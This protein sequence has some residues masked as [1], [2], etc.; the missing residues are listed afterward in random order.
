MPR[1]RSVAWSEL[2][3]GI[4]AVV[5]LAVLV[6]VIF[7]VGGEGGFWWDRYP[8]KVRFAD[9]QGLKAGAV[10]RVSGKEVGT[11]KAVEFA[12]TE[13][14]VD[15]EVLKTVRPLI[16]TESVASIGSLS[17]LGEPLVDVSAATGGTPLADNAVVKAAPK[18]GS[19]GDLTNSASSS[20]E[21]INQ[22]VADV[23]AGKG[24]LGKVVTDDALYTELQAFVASAGRVTQSINEGR[25]TLG[26]LVRDPAAYEALRTS[27]Q[28]L[29]AMTAKINSGEGALGKFL[30]DEALGRSLSGSVTNVEKITGGLS[31]GEGTAGQLLTDRQLYDQLNSVTKRMDQVVAGLESG[32]GTAG[33]LLHDQQLYENMNRAVTE[34]RD[35][36]ADARK[37]PKKFLNVRVSIF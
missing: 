32:S 18:A 31:R 24:T 35:L 14:E 2:K 7:A 12:G 9:A 33:K 27:L 1:T 5:A 21:Q 13:I 26:G 3:I 4:V 25:G 8:L 29:Q 20:L 17:L 30:N 11:V 28:N 22:L 10:V 16:T 15:L 34:L 36:L 19:I 37:D 6:F 23:R